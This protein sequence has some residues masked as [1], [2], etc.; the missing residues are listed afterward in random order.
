M[1]GLLWLFIFTSAKRITKYETPLLNMIRLINKIDLHKLHDY[2]KDVAHS[3]VR[4]RLI[5]SMHFFRLL[6]RDRSTKMDN[7]IVFLD[8]KTLGNMPTESQKSFSKYP[9]IRKNGLENP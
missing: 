5:L 4:S 6:N 8:P 2:E 3:K 1:R 7:G 9:K